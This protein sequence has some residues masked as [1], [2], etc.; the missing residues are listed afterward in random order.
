MVARA[1]AAVVVWD[2]CDAAVRDLLGRL[3]RKGVPVRVIVP[4]MP[5]AADP[6]EEPP[7]AR[8]AYWPD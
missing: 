1:D 4:G 5:G 7:P 3:K 8:A 2:R 6:P